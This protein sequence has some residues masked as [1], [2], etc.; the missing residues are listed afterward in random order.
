MKISAEAEGLR[1][2]VL[3]A[4]D[5]GDLE[6]FDAAKSFVRQLFIFA[7]MRFGG[8][9]F[10]IQQRMMSELA[11]K[12]I[13][14]SDRKNPGQ[15]PISMHILAHASADNRRALDMAMDFAPAIYDLAGFP[16]REKLHDIVQLYFGA[17]CQAPFAP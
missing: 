3:W 16:S 14:L 12:L 15:V 9:E 4:V 1:R 5:Q 11:D 10:R 7:H 13:R 2:F 17:E 8:N 6:L